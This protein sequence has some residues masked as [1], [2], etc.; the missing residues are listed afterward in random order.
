MEGALD[1]LFDRL[2]MMMMM[3]IFRCVIPVVLHMQMK[4]GF[5]L[6]SKHNYLMISIYYIDN[7]FRPQEYWRPKRNPLR[8]YPCIRQIIAARF[9][10]FKKKDFLSSP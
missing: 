7:M 4:R 2:L 3:M 10:E 8:F 1:L 9:N 6:K 5:L